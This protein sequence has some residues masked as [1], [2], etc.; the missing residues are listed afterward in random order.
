MCARRVQRDEIVCTA[1]GEHKYITSSLITIL[2][3]IH[4]MPPSETSPKR[5]RLNDS[6]YHFASKLDQT[7]GALRTTSDGNLID[8]DTGDWLVLDTP[9]HEPEITSLKG[10]TIG[11]PESK[12]GA[13]GLDNP[14]ARKS[15]VRLLRNKILGSDRLPPEE[16]DPEVVARKKLL[17]EIGQIREGASGKVDMSLL[18]EV[19]KHY[20]D[21]MGHCL[22][23]DWFEH[24][25][26]D[27]EFRGR[28]LD[29][30]LE[31]GCN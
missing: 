26:V 13:T 2:L 31:I 8:E 27:E 30:V 16:E 22:G 5:P 11:L 7:Q 18:G 19:Q 14:R 1:I 6:V 21:N 25:L 20:G 17:E 3:S 10:P 28:V 4:A 24:A 29:K 12:N 15:L 9:A 23:G